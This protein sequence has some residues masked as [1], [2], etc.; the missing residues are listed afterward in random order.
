MVLGAVILAMLAGY[1]TVGFGLAAGWGVVI[2]M[3][4]GWLAGVLTLLAV[5][6]IGARVCVARTL[7]ERAK[8]ARSTG[9]AT[10]PAR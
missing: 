9:F 1:G 2:S 6:L 3:L 7:A 8:S 4:V 5:G 10:K